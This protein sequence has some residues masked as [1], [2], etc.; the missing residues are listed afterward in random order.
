MKKGLL[1]FAAG[2]L[3]GELDPVGLLAWELVEARLPAVK[4]RSLSEP[5]PFEKTPRSWWIAESEH[6]FAIEDRYA[7]TAPVHLLVISKERYASLLEAPTAT[8]GEMLDLA[9][10][11]ARERGIAEPGFRIVV[12]TN[13]Q[14]GQTV[15]H[16]HVHVKGGRQM[17]EPLLPLL[18]SWLRH[19][20]TA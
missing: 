20:A 19:G 3:I 9:R 13:P 14:G 2:L 18:W 5:S 6:A 8:L 15:Y 16:L 10:R 17:R 11:L 4:S 1:V 7:P 12:N